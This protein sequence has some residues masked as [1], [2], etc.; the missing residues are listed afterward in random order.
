MSRLP[1]ARSAVVVAAIAA[2]AAV[3]VAAGVAAA[4]AGDPCF[5]P[6]PAAVAHR[7]GFSA[8]ERPLALRAPDGGSLSARGC[9]SCHA[10]VYA[11]WQTTRHRAAWDNAV[12]L[13][14]L[15]REPLARCVH[16]HAPLV[17]QK[18]EVG[19]LRGRPFSPS[20]SSSLVH[21]GVTCAVCHVRDGRVLTT[22]P[23]RPDAATPMHD[24]VIEPA[25]KDPAFCASCHQFGFSGS[26]VLMQGTWS[27]WRAF[28]DAGGQG[29]CQGC[30]MPGGRHLFRG[31]WDRDL[32]R[33][34]LVVDVDRGADG[35]A[36]VLRSRGVG[37]HFPTGDLFRHLTV[38]VSD[39]DRAGFDDDGAFVA[40][41]RVGRT[42][43]GEGLD[44]RVVEDTS[45]VPGE[46]RRVPLP[47]STRRWRV[48]YHY[49]EARHERADVVAPVVIAAGSR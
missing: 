4:P 23:V 21:E 35:L 32:L 1:V 16:C 42:F 6:D 5:A 3:V 12:F 38:E 49:A 25:L 14:G 28:A 20:S 31:A 15:R 44:K 13:D 30:H 39:V 26:D 10:E 36:L 7:L 24:V 33:D 47:P 37:H 43:G 46:P 9:G 29:T 40:V 45:L 17:E 27:E 22:R 18:R 8:G 11:D 34:S 19:P 48:R 2:V 41:F